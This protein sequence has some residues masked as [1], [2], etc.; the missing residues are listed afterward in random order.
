MTPENF[1]KFIDSF[2]GK[3]KD[4]LGAK[5]IEYAKNNDKLHNFKAAAAFAYP[6]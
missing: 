5:N 1:F 6:V 4:L 2:Y 3:C